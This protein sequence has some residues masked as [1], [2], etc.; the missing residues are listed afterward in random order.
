M[1]IV[2]FTVSLIGLQPKAAGRRR[3]D[4]GLPAIAKRPCGS[5]FNS[6][7]IIILKLNPTP[8]AMATADQLGKWKRE[9]RNAI[10]KELGK[11]LQA[12]LEALPENSARCDE[13]RLL[14]SQLNDTN[15]GQIMGTRS[16]D[17]LDAAYN[18]LRL[19]ALQFV[20]TLSLADFNPEAA[21]FTPP[22]PKGVLLHKIPRQMQLGRA[23]TC[24]I[25][26]A[27]DRAV[28][29][30]NLELS[31]EVK[32]R[33]IAVSKVMEA[34]LID[35][36]ADAAF[37]IRSFHDERQ[38]LE[39]GAY[40]EWTFYV[41]PLRAGTFPLLLKLTVI[42]AID[43]EKEK[44]N[45]T[46]EEEVRIAAEAPQQL[47]EG[48]AGFRASGLSVAFRNPPPGKKAAAAPAAEESG[49][50]VPSLLEDI[51][52]E[53]IYEPPPAYREPNTQQTAFPGQPAPRPRFPWASAASVAL[54][55]VAAAW[56]FWP[57][58]AAKPADVAV[59]EP[60]SKEQPEP[61]DSALWKEENMALEKAPPEKA[62]KLPLEK[63]PKAE[64]HRIPRRP[65]GPEWPATI[66]GPLKARRVAS[67][68]GLRLA[69]TPDA[70]IVINVC[71]DA[72]GKVVRST[73]NP[74]ASDSSAPELQAQLLDH[75]KQ[76]VFEP[77]Q[78]AL[79]GTLSYRI[80]SH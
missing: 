52:P 57:Y 16:Q 15:R 6:F 46:W 77:G 22:A 56:W 47:P 42:A 72:K 34:E 23:E 2:F 48:E 37:Q 25:R 14:L 24:I 63:Q 39:H 74:S 5:N 53:P 79:C 31:A 62:I 13:L 26:L 38:F 18:S 9:W 64:A 4:S 36:N 17:E 51:M 1:I 3:K 76:W 49:A 65:D 54:L 32:V 58:N 69:N 75:A 45:I 50:A 29:A 68:P 59:G 80:R 35:P 60:G 21:G 10:S 11:A 27:Y 7:F 71:I 28:I 73:F 30:D 43:G 66:N 41:T 78:G 12:I 20:N 67:A 33:D 19:R 40:T 70:Q 44:R 55:L 8:H 61:L